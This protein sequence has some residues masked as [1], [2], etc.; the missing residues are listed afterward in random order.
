MGIF[1]TSKQELKNVAMFLLRFSYGAGVSFQ[2][3]G[4]KE[5]VATV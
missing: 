3:K 2:K 1:T 4:Q 5:G